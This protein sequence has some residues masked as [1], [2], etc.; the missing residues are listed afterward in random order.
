V[1]LQ[2]GVNKTNHP[3]QNPLLLV[4]EPQTCDNIVNVKTNR[5]N[6]EFKVIS[7]TCVVIDS[8]VIINKN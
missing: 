4:T 3:I 6:D 1:F 5:D 8:T 2:E 7:R